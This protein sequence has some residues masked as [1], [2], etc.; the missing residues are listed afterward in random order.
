MSTNKY[1]DEETTEN[2]SLQVH[3]RSIQY[4]RGT[5]STYT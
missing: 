5:C 2:K 4:I 1:I 3:E